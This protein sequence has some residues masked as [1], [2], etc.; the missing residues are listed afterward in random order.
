MTT[1]LL[2]NINSPLAVVDAVR[3]QIRRISN[4]AKAARKR[5]MVYRMT[6]NELNNYSPREL[7]DIGIHRSQ[8]RRLAM[9]QANQE[10]TN[11]S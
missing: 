3:T 8:I 6:M 2:S 10:Q 11:A 5:R 7:A 9:E 4:A 1:M